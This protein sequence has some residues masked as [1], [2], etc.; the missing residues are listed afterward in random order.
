MSNYKLRNGE[1]VNVRVPQEKDAEGVIFV[2]KQVDTESKFLGRA[3]GEFKTSVEREKELIKDVADDSDSSW[4]IAEYR[5]KVV[6]Q[7]SVGLVRRNR[8]FRHRAGLGFVLLKD[9]WN[10]G[11]GGKMMQEC[12]K[13]AKEHNIEQLE[14]EV[15]TTN[16]HALKMYKSFGFKIVGTVYKELKYD[17]G[18]YAN[19]YMMQ[20]ELN[21]DQSSMTKNQ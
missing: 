4:F 2:M 13:W 21:N 20:L 16:E 8:R 7:C 11:I 10:L 14:L 18:S 5:G 15:V 17:D 9:Y 3:P 1:E 12:I 6:G 19:A